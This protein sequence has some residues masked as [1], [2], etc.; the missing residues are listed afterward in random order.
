LISF[1]QQHKRRLINK[2]KLLKQSKGRDSP[3]FFFEVVSFTPAASALSALPGFASLPATARA[4]AAL[5]WC[6]SSLLKRPRWLAALATAAFLMALP[7]A[8]WWVFCSQ[9]QRG[10]ER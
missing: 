2:R 10:R 4:A 5:M 1:L 8:W 6:P 9:R 7:M 3:Y